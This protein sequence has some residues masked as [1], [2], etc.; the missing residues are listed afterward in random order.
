MKTKDKQKN[1]SYSK[2]FVIITALSIAIILTSN[3]TAGKLINIWKFILPSSVILFPISYIIGDIVAEVYGY[4]KAKMIIFLGF[5]CNAI[6]VSFFALAI[7]LPHPES[8][9]DQEA[10]KSILGTTPRIFIAS[11]IAFLA[12]GLSNAYVMSFL[13]KITK[14]KKLWV[15]TIGSTIIGEFLDTF[16]FVFIGFFGIVDSNIIFTMIISQWIWKVSYEVFATPITYFVINIY[17]K[18]DEKNAE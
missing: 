15:R 11:L 8:W 10:F 16:L 14:G 7:V 2:Y 9:Q 6:M 13:K 17:K 5:L 18:L 12:G 1:Q 4:K 3:V